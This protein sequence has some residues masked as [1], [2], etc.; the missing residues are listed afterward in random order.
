MELTGQIRSI[1]KTQMVSDKFSKREFTII[2]NPS[3]E[4]PQTIQ[5]ELHKDRCEIIDSFKVGDNVKV[6][7]NLKVREW[8]NPQGETKTFNPL[9]AWAVIL[10]N[11]SETKKPKMISDLQ[12]VKNTFSEWMKLASYGKLIDINLPPIV[13]EEKKAEAR[14]KLNKYLSWKT[15]KT[16]FTKAI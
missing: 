6:N 8:K 15:T 10:L 12:V 5:F 13:C 14:N 7:F 9:Q 1:G 4:Y 3:A 11:K 2:D 16:G